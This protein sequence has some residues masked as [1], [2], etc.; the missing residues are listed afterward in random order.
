M[1]S[2]RA[3]DLLDRECER[4]QQELARLGE[5]VADGSSELFE[6]ERDQSLI[7]TLRSELA[8]IERAKKRLAEGTFGISI[9]SGAPIPDE[10]LEVQPWA[11]RTVDEQATYETARRYAGG[12]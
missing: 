11:E 9:E 12:S 5:H 4:I 2:Q 8:A 7:K 1:D 10:R 6:Q 3:H